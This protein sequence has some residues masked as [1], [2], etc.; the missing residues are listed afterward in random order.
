MSQLR[1]YRVYTFQALFFDFFSFFFLLFLRRSSFI[2]T[3]SFR[4]C[5][6]A[7]GSF[8]LLN[9]FFSYTFSFISTYIHHTYSGSEKE[10][11]KHGWNKVGCG[12]RIFPCMKNLIRGIRSLSSILLLLH[13]HM[14]VTACQEFTRDRPDQRYRED[15]RQ[16]LLM[17]HPEKARG[18]PPAKSL[19]K[20]KGQ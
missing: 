2:L 4:E 11:R 10:E 19:K 9:F 1:M 7:H 15:R 13:V 3:F 16:N 12:M 8:V 18:V 5:R 17:C 20:K 14:T 6:A